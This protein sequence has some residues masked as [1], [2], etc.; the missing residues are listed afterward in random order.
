MKTRKPSICRDIRTVAMLASLLATLS[1]AGGC[2]RNARQQATDG[3]SPVAAKV[4]DASV[5]SFAQFQDEI[6]AHRGK[7]VVVDLWALW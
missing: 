4:A 5:V 3:A 2:S 6:S 7:V 1:T